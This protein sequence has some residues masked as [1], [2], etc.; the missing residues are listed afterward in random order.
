LSSGRGQF[1]KIKDNLQS[2]V[3]TGR[4]FIEMLNSVLTAPKTF[5]EFAGVMAGVTKFHKALLQA[6][7]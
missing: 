7:I 4:V 2:A 1:A 3:V 5:A 6:T